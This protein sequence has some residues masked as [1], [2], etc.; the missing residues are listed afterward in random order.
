MKEKYR[1][2][3]YQLANIGHWEVDFENDELYWSDEIKKLHEV[4]HDYEP[5]LETAITFYEKGEHRKSIQEAISHAIEKGE[6]FTIESKIITAKGNQR[7]I[8]AIGEP[9][10]ENGRCL[11]LYGS[12]QNITDRKKAEQKIERQQKKLRDII[13]HSTIMF[14]RH[15]T[16]HNLTYVSPQSTRF[17]GYSPQEAKQ[18]WTHFITDHPVNRKAIAHTERAIKTGESQPPYELQLRKAD[19]KKI[20]VKVNESPIVEGGKTVEIVGSMTDITE[21]KN[22]QKE[23]DLLSRVASETQNMVIITDSRERI[24]W[25]NKA[26][27][28]ITGY[29]KDEALGKNPG[30]LLQGPETDEQT[31]KR[32]AQKIREKKSFSEEILNY[33][34]EGKAYW[35]KMD[36]TPITDEKGNVSQ[37][38]S[39]QEDITEQKNTLQQF[40]EKESQ[41]RNMANNVDGMIHQYRRYPD[42]QEEFVYISEGI[43]ELHEIT[44]EE[45]IESSELL[46]SQI[47]DDHIDEVRASVTESAKQMTKWDQKWKIETPSG[48][49][50]WIHGRGTPRK[51]ED[52]SILWDTI[53]L[54][55]TKQ[56]QAKKREQELHRIIEESLNEV[57]I[58]DAD[59]LQFQFVNSIAKQHTGYS[60]EELLGMSPLD[61]TKE[62]TPDSFRKLLHPLANEYEQF[63][64]FETIHQQ[65]DGSSYPVEVSLRKDEFNGQS[66]YIA[67]IL[68][69]SE[70]K[71]LEKNISRQISLLNNILDSTPGLFYMVNKDMTFSRTNQNVKTFFGLTAKE[72]QETNALS[73][74]APR[75]RSKAT[76]EIGKAFTNGYADLET[77]LIDK[78]GEEYHFF[79]NGSRIELDGNY[80]VIGMGIDI[81]ERVKAEEENAIL[82]QE[83][84][85]RVKNNLAIIS[86]ILMLELEE[87][88]PKNMNR[89]PLERSINRIISIGKVHELLYQSSSFSKVNTAKYVGELVQSVMDTFS[90]SKNIEVNIDT[91]QDLAININQTIPLGMLL[92][93]FITNSIKYAFDKAGHGL[94]TI[95]IHRKQNQ[96]YV[97]YKDNGKGFEPQVFE[98]SKTLGFTIIHTL[99]S[100]LN[101]DYEFSSEDGFEIVLSF[102][103]NNKGS[104]SNIDI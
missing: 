6:S 93:E 45:A 49:E 71:L 27:T 86:G 3:A 26:F 104:H 31:V 47:D 17:L 48:K 58:F 61:L 102:K 34:K 2:Q 28:Q 35:L 62:Y 81:S 7:W 10:F 100:Q 16:D 77:I 84:H 15:D 76:S 24:E 46:W 97:T 55:I 52:G 64:Q 57:Y 79:M 30:N 90:E 92:N 51:L 65:S 83:I 60:E 53:L 4:P 85:H 95:Q 42:G 103:E 96:Y 68:D 80:Y 88:S 44:P 9:E 59:S 70:Q 36:V 43:R 78:N 75:E 40:K 11:R 38:F 12:T 50:K 33:T 25:V 39:I 22:Q 20:W 99:L 5:D 72:L 82:L 94:I 54:D 1:K 98:N 101:A 41:L 21:L 89:L 69:I 56:E 66:V 87:L 67:A 29:S 73:L 91:E 14:Y 74:I 13:E 23:L 32:I 37:F 63:I 18:K 19:G 8:K